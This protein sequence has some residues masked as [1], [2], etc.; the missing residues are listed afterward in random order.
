MRLQRSFVFAD[1]ENILADAA[2]QRPQHGSI[3]TDILPPRNTRH[4]LKHSRPPPP[5]PRRWYRAH[6]AC[7]RQ[8]SRRHVTNLLYVPTPFV[9]NALARV[10][11]VFHAQVHVCAPLAPF[12]MQSRA[13]PG[14]AVVHVVKSACVVVCLLARACGSAALCK[15]VV[16]CCGVAPVVVVHG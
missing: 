4:D 8:R 3:L 2:R 11:C 16:V 5:P 15:R 9:A 14:N 10:S 13:L 6:I 12:V 7:G 1:V